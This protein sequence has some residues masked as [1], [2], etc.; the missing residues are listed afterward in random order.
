MANIPKTIQELK[1]FCD[2]KGMP[3]EKMRFFI[4]K[5]FR[6][7]CAFGIYKDGSWYVVYKNKDNGSR[8]VRYHGPDEAYAVK[9]I[10]LKLLDECHNRGIYP[11]RDENDQEKSSEPSEP[12]TRSSVRQEDI[13]YTPES[14]AYPTISG[15][16]KFIIFLVI[17]A[18]LGFGLWKFV[19]VPRIN[20]VD[21]IT[22]PAESV[23]KVEDAVTKTSESTTTTNNDAN[24]LTTMLILAEPI[25]NSSLDTTY[26]DT[27]TQDTSYSDSWS[28]N[29]D[30][31]D[32]SWSD[33]SSYD[34]S[35]SWSSSYDSWDYSSTD[36][37]SDW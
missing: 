15:T 18:L 23:Q 37:S 34:Y 16:A 28:S 17:A 19:F 7:P 22:A 6:E 20:S 27:S 26:Q 25:L 4:G 11:D 31:V 33:T 1:D 5:D 36:W 24:D 32:T 9:E 2:S 12:V 10:Y 35:D 3:L 29:D 8:A 13:V 30:Y 14:R 21:A